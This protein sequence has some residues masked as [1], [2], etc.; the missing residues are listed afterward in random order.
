M[1]DRKAAVS[2][3]DKTKGADK[4]FLGP[5]AMKLPGVIKGLGES[6]DSLK[7]AT[8]KAPTLLTHA[9]KTGEALTT[10]QGT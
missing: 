9:Q 5:N 8:T 1:D 6:T 2:G 3:A 10:L 7:A 4:T